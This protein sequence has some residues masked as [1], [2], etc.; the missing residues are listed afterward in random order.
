MVNRV[1]R[2]DPSKG[3]LHNRQAITLRRFW[4]SLK[5]FHMWPIYAIGLIWMI[6]SLPA[7][8]YLTLQLRSQGFTTFQTNFR[9]CDDFIVILTLLVGGPSVQPV[10]VSLTSRNAESVRTRTVDSALYNI[11][12]Q[13]GAIASAN[14]YQAKDEP[15][16]KNG[17][18]TLIALA[19]A[20]G[21]IFVAAKFYYDWLN[22]YVPIFLL[23]LEHPC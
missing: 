11:S 21:F 6:P 8:G 7:G 5:D 10:V 14:V 15:Y 3:S 16:Y 13:V 1:I 22:K 23:M 18:K 12:V 17:N 9:P 20:G 4:E 2:D 19:I